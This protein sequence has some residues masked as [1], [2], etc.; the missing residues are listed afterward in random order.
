MSPA[1][2][3][4]LLPPLVPP[5]N[6]PPL[7]TSIFSLVVSLVIFVLVPCSLFRLPLMAPNFVESNPDGKETVTKRPA[8]TEVPDTVGCPVSVS[9][10]DEEGVV[11]LKLARTFPALCR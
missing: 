4:P 2:S 3:P 1:P 9:M 5:H 6:Y 10:A 11:L 8:V 7:W